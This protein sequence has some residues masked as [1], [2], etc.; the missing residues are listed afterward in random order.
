MINIDNKI[1]T[2][3]VMKIISLCSDVQFEQFQSGLKKIYEHKS[4]HKINNYNDIIKL[5]N[6]QNTNDDDDISDSCNYDFNRWTYGI[7]DSYDIMVGYFHNDAHNVKD[8]LLSY[9]IDW[10]LAIKHIID[11]VKERTKEHEYKSLEV[12]VDNEIIKN[13]FVDYFGALCIKSRDE[14]SF[15]CCIVT[16]KESTNKKFSGD[17]K[18]KIDRFSHCE[19][20]DK[21]KIESHETNVVIGTINDSY[22]CGCIVKEPILIFET[23]IVTQPVFDDVFIDMYLYVNGVKY[24]VY[25]PKSVIKIREDSQLRLDKFYQKVDSVSYDEFD[26]MNIIYGIN[27]WDNLEIKKRCDQYKYFHHYEKVKKCRKGNCDCVKDCITINPDAVILSQLIFDKL[28]LPYEKC[29]FY[30]K[31]KQFRISQ[32]FTPKNIINMNEKNNCVVSEYCYII[33]LR[34]FHSQKKNIYKIGKTKQLNFKRF[35]GYPKGSI[36]KIFRE[37]SDCTKCENEMIKVL[38]CNFKKR[39][40]IGNEYYEGEYNKIEEQ[41]ISVTDNFRCQN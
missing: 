25:D 34:E 38:N 32:T 29:D 16:I 40:D 31:D 6:E 17:I 19:R 36:I 14:Y 39:N 24:N 26:D 13:I 12:V 37:V 7:V 21:N 23:P 28:K 15:Y 2:P 27:V 30:N 22:N 3:V 41:F 10:I 33:H 11:F 35:S 5:Q 20:R 4:K 8:I 1:C 9:D 18:V